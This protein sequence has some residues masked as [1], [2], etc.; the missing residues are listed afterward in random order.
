[1]NALC[2]I[3]NHTYAAD[4][5]LI[6]IILGLQSCSSLHPCPWCTVSSKNLNKKG[7]I[8]TFGL[9]KQ[10]YKQ[11]KESGGAI[12]SSKDFGTLNYLYILSAKINDNYT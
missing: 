3:V 7:D 5:K 8:R 2:G 4:L 12:S 10:K 6:M 9:I 1:M 11:W